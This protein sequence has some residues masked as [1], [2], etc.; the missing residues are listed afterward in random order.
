MYQLFACLFMAA[1]FVLI[2]GM[3]ICEIVKAVSKIEKMNENGKRNL[4]VL[5]ILGI[6]T[7]FIF[8]SIAFC[9]IYKLAKYFA[10]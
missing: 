9:A 2:S 1:V 3:I 6:P 8:Y 10:N 7:S 4:I 5:S